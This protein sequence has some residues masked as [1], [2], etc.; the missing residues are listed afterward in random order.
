M[1]IHH[2]LLAE[3]PD[4]RLN[5]LLLIESFAPAASEADAVRRDE[6]ETALSENIDQQIR[7]S[8]LIK[9]LDSPKYIPQLYSR[10]WILV[11]NKWNEFISN[12]DQSM[13]QSS[14]TN[15]EPSTL[16]FDEDSREVTPINS[17]SQLLAVLIISTV[18]IARDFIK[19]FNATKSHPLMKIKFLNN[20]IKREIRKRNITMACLNQAIW[21][22][23]DPI[24]NIQTIIAWIWWVTVTTSLMWPYF[25]YRE[26]KAFKCCFFLGN[27]I[28][29]SF[30]LWTESF[31]ISSLSRLRWVP[32]HH[33]WPIVR[34]SALAIQSPPGRTS[35]SHHHFPS[36]S[37][38]LRRALPPKFQRGSCP[39]IHFVMWT[40]SVVLVRQNQR[41][42]HQEGLPETQPQSN[43]IV[44]L[45]SQCHFDGITERIRR[46]CDASPN[47]GV[48]IARRQRLPLLEEQL[49]R[50]NQWKSLHQVAHGGNLPKTNRKNSSNLW[51]GT[52][53]SSR[54]DF[55]AFA[56]QA[57][58]H[59][60]KFIANGLDGCSAQF[61]IE[62]IHR[63]D[64][65]S[66]QKFQWITVSSCCCLLGTSDHRCHVLQS[67]AE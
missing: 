3:E 50:F 18:T 10:V 33:H 60:Y 13:K 57:L 12:Y 37:L 63:I 29:D 54:I 5:E 47:S 19:G 34:V 51:V 4:L 20:L 48:C 43:R 24:R 31:L 42:W 28:F 58:C 52:Q 66:P 40:K 11:S 56:A 22:S 7:R 1:R 16:S 44:F 67:T 2:L 15:L 64:N 53:K 26:F 41:Q 23:M 49:W 25:L 46:C 65:G 21:A 8:P 27:E 9:I 55:L 39:A 14:I 17:L 61:L 30:P 32:Q 59:F 62:T 45:G 35:N 6:S 36:A 38:H